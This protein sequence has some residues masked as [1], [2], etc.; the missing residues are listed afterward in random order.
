MSNPDLTRYLAAI[1]HAA[2][3]IDACA[4]EIAE[5]TR[6]LDEALDNLITVAQAAKRE[7]QP[8]ESK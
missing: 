4:Q 6:Q 8:R 5:G 7:I 2:K 1:K 3:T